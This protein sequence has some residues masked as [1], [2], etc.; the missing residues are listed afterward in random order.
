M[1]K[2]LLRRAVLA[3]AIAW[4]SA[5][6]PAWTAPPQLKP[7]V[8]L[9]ASPA[10]GDPNFVETVV[11]LVQHG[12]DGSM[13]L[14][15]NRPTRVPVREAVDALAE[16]RG[17]ELRLYEGGPV[18]RDVTLALV[19]TPKRLADAHRVLPDVQ[20]STESKRWKELARDPEVES[21]LRVYAGYAGWGPGQLARELRLGSWVVAPADARSVFSSEPSELWPRVHQLMK[22]IEARQTAPGRGPIPGRC[23]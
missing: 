1:A 3:A 18:Q 19:R 16:I 20:L 4:V 9:Y 2:H 8:F 15:V 7:G 21:R 6:A 14:V 13:G 17:L 23:C 10:L 11:L 22:R 12:P 5:A